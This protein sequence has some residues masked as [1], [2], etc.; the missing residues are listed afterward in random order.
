MSVSYYIGRV[1]GHSPEQGPAES[2]KRI[3]REFNLS[4]EKS[5]VVDKLS[6]S[7][8]TGSIGCLSHESTGCG[9]VRTLFQ[10]LGKDKEKGKL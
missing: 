2:K 6:V 8:Q 5:S 1:C 4:G 9:S 3:S 10:L 7:N